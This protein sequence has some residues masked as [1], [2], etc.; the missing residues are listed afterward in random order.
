VTWGSENKIGLYH[1]CQ[2]RFKKQYKGTKCLCS[3]NISLDFLCS[4]K[5]TVFSNWSDFKQ[6]QE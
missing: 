4:S 3:L 6:A 1:R 2:Y 5:E